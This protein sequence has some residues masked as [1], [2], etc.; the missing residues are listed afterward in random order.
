MLF[1]CD[2]SADIIFFFFKKQTN[3]NV[4]KQQQMVQLVYRKGETAESYF[5]LTHTPPANRDLY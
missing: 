4:N 1:F 3:I 2:I 5:I